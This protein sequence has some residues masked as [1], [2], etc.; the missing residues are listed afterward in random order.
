MSTTRDRL[1]DAAEAV[2]AAEGADAVT[3][4]RVAR[5]TGLSHAAPLR[6]FPTLP[7]LLATVAT[8]GFHALSVA[9][10]G[11]AVAAAGDDP[12]A[13]LHAAATAYTCFALDQP[14]LFTL[15]FRH[16]LLDHD[17]PQLAAAGAEAFGALVALVVDAQR[18]GWHADV[19]PRQVAGVLWATTH[20]LSHLW[21]TG[22]YPAVTD[23]SSTA[24]AIDILTRIYAV[25]TATYATPLTP[26][27]P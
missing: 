1:L 25:P 26:E 12:R 14:A 24:D 13:R 5:D 8:R 6:H 4:R 20:G 2:L 3:I 27:I 17:D 21:L 10:R 11:A 9:V 16:D 19:N 22:G 15:M 18:A 7:A 23:T